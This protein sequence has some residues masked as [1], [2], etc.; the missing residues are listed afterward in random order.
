M[1]VS[2]PAEQATADDTV[3]EEQAAK[4]TVTAQSAPANTTAFGE[5][6]APGMVEALDLPEAENTSKA[7][8]V[9]AEPAAQLVE[10]PPE[11]AAAPS[12]EAALASTSS[13]D[14]ASAAGAALQQKRTAL[15]F[16]EDAT[17]VPG[18]SF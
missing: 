4:N 18:V 7:H 12:E 17:D 9:E 1:R 14:A 8:H 10:E 5:S 3:A 2:V 13:K 16:S 11:T 15:R 6:E